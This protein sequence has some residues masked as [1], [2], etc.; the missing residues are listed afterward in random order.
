MRI[1]EFLKELLPLYIH[2]YSPMNGI[3]LWQPSRV[4]WSE[5]RRPLVRC[6]ANHQMNRVSQWP[7][8]MMTAL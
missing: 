3:P 2:L 7:V 1:W 5:G 4:A 6:S 8:V